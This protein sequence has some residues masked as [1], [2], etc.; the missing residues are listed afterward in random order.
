MSTSYERWKDAGHLAAE[1]IDSTLHTRHRWARTWT[2]VLVAQSLVIGVALFW[3]LGGNGGVGYGGESDRSNGN[4][5]V[6]TF[7]FTL[8]GATVIVAG[9]VWARR[10]GRYI[11]LDGLVIRALAPSEQRYVRRQIAGKEIV[12]WA[13]LP[14]RIAVALQSQR[15]LEALVPLL[16]GFLLLYGPLSIRAGDALNIYTSTGISVCLVAAALS[17]DFLYRRTDAF[18]DRFDQPNP[19]FD[20]K[21]DA[22]RDF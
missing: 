3:I 4:P 10:S 8:L 19:V 12:D 16:G 9:L 11:A 7:I 5:N 18:L 17:V 15:A 20:R 14:V 21:Y 22:R 13:R 2:R 1:V 6:A